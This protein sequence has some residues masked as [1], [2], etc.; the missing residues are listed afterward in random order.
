MNIFL[1]FGF[2]CAVGATAQKCD[3]EKCPPGDSSAGGS[4]GS[5]NTSVTGGNSAT[6]GTNSTSSTETGGFSTGGAEATGG[7]NSTGG[8][9]GSMTCMPKDMACDVSSPLPCCSGV[10]GGGFCQ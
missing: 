6:G 4:A 3:Y 7:A 10:C 5:S 2:L 8:D 1:T 9:T